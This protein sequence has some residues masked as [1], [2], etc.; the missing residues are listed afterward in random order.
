MN[1]DLIK[2]NFEHGLWTAKMVAMA[3]V[4]G[5]ITAEQYK[6]ITGE[7]YGK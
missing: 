2:K 1:F 4:K 7:E 5:I 3:V 6:D